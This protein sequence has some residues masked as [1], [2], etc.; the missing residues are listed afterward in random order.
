MI[1]LTGKTVLVTGAARGIGRAVCLSF[2]QA[3]A[4]VVASDLAGRVDSVP[5]ETASVSDLERTA[6]LVRQEGGSCEIAHADVRNP[7]ELDAAASMAMERFGSLDLLVANAGIASFGQST[8]QLDPQQ[9][10]DML[11][12]TLT[13]TWNTCRS[14]IPYMLEGGRGGSLVIVSSTAA[15]KSLPTIGHYSAAK[16]GQV[17]LMRSLALELAEHSVRV[18]TVHPGGTGTPMTENPRSEEWQAT[19]PGLSDTLQLPLPIHRME[20]ID[21]AHAIRWLCSDEARYVT[22]QTVIVDAGALL[23]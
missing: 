22:G 19:V 13:G 18:N 20:P 17:G 12:V 23:R 4:S 9:W 14:A 7:D 10:Q 5:Y 15:I 3:G 11:D 2:A 16:L 1:E 21:I 6:E 8:W